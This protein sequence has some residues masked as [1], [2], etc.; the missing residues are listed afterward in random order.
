MM[1]VAQGVS[2][3][4]KGSVMRRCLVAL[5]LLALCLLAFVTQTQAQDFDVPTLR[6]TSPFIPASPKYTRW[7]GFY[8]GGQ[9]GLS[10]SNMDFRDAFDSANI[11]DPGNQ[12]TAPLGLVSTW[13]AFGQKNVRSTSYGGFVG[14]NVQF[15]EAVVG[16]EVNYNRT[17]AFGS[18]SDTRCYSDTN[19]SCFGEISLGGND[20][21]VNVTALASVNITDYGTF[22]GRAGWAYG[23]FLAYAIAG[24][25]VA[26]AEV[27]RTA[28]ADATPTPT[29]LGTA[30][31]HTET[32]RR[33]RFTWGYSLG[34]GV[35]YLI[36]PN[37]FVRGEYEYI[38]L[39][40]LANINLSINTARV[41]VG[42]KF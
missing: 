30:F 24:V 15:S 31:V 14:Y 35:D 37:V 40:P 4:I 42:L 25:A 19:P 6:G 27:I 23:N 36:M 38:K 5:C 2:A 33:T 20:Y 9:I 41:G 22:R 29:S 3:R 17:N 8:G 39:N 12:L 10:N 28:T 34:V 32:E 13:G 11:F 21:N 26:R 16:L 18:A 7:A 1:T